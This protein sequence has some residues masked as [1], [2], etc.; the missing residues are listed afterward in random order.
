MKYFWKENASK[1][2][3]SSDSHIQAQ[4]DTLMGIIG[5]LIEAI[6][7]PFKMIVEMFF[8]FGGLIE[9]SLDI[10]MYILLII[11]F[12]ALLTSVF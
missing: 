9:Q 4:E 2:Y 12:I 5:A 11:A 6:L 7:L 3:F 1:H 10:I 8:M